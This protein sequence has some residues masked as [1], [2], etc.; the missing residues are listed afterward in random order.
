[1]APEGRHRNF[2]TEKHIPVVFE[3]VRIVLRC[4]LTMNDFQGLIVEPEG[5]DDGARQL[6]P[7]LTYH[8]GTIYPNRIWTYW[9]CSE[10][11]FDYDRL[12]GSDNGAFKP[13]ALS[14]DPG[15]QS[16]SK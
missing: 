1:M 9:N 8:N 2:I 3:L 5:S 12:L 7:E 16:R 13:P 4:S 14:S 11:Y 6:A 15:N 10:M